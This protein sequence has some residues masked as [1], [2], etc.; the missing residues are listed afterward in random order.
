MSITLV[1]PVNLTI[2]LLN[3]TCHMFLDILTM[4]LSKKLKTF[5]PPAFKFHH[6]LKNGHAI[7]QQCY[8]SA[9][10]IDENSGG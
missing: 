10:L 4:S 7:W 2:S 5:L 8:N 3:K 1:K 6:S 9:S